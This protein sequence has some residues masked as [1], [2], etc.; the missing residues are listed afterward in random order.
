MPTLTARFRLPDDFDADWVFG[1]LAMRA[2][3][4]LETCELV[5]DLWRYRRRGPCGSVTLEA[6]AKNAR[7]VRVVSE[8][9][10]PADTEVRL[11][12]LL[13]LDKPR[14]DLAEVF[15]ADALLGPV[16]HQRPG[17][18]VPGAWDAFELAVRAVLGQQVSVERARR[19]CLAL[20]DRFGD[21]D[22]PSPEKLVDADVSAIGMP[23]V[24]GGAVRALAAFALEDGFNFDRNPLDAVC[25][26]LLALPGIGPWT[27]AYIRLRAGRDMDAFPHSDWVVLKQLQMTAPKA[28]KRAEAWR[29]WRG[30]ALMYL[31]HL[32][33]LAR[34]SEAL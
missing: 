6:K 1:F 29:P 10:L 14:V 13:S 17:L 31:W 7:T 19:L 34:E 11:R 18:S 25:E 16:A 22:F 28:L 21:G 12:R 8:G 24:R 30:I 5:D 2:L 32:S 33:G 23:G 27:V 9:L 15:A 4:P 26:G 3:P 20:I